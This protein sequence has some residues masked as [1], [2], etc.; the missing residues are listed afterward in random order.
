M[1]GHCSQVGIVC[2]PP[3]ILVEYPILGIKNVLGFIELGA[4]K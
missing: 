2:T 3:M 1:I 4:E